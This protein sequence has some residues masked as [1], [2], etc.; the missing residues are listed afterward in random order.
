MVSWEL[1]KFKVEKTNKS[2]LNFETEIVIPEIYKDITVIYDDKQL[3]V[4]GS[5][6]KQDYVTTY[7]L[8]LY[9][10]QASLAA[11]I[12]GVLLQVSPQVHGPLYQVKE[13]LGYLRR[14]PLLLKD[15]RY[16]LAQYWLDQGD[17]ELVPQYEAYLAGGI[18]LLSQLNYYGLY[19][20]RR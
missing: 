11:C 4:W 8:G 3:I 10:D 16:A 18:A 7:D 5:E 12:L 1:T 17:S 2:T 20:L 19:L 15:L 13:V 6:L 9:Q 14:Q